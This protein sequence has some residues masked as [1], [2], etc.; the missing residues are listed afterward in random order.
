WRHGNSRPS[1][2]LAHARFRAVAA[3]GRHQVVQQQPAL[4]LHARRRLAPA[5]GRRPQPQRDRRQRGVRLR[6]FYSSDCASGATPGYFF[7]PNGDYDVYDFRSPDDTRVSDEARAVLEGHVDTGA[8]SHD[9]SIGADAFRRT[10]DNRA[11]V[12]AYG[13]TANIDKVEPP[14]FA[15]SPNQPGPSVRRI[16]SWQHSL[17]ALDRLHLGE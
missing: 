11:Y 3:A 5:H 12:Y 10:L 7:A 13:G 1:G 4:R 16:T 17:F 8:L 14:Y 15:P 9:V 6:C 2:Q